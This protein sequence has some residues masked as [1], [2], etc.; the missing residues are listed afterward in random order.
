VRA[1]TADIDGELCGLDEDGLPSFAETQAATD[2]AS[3]THLVFYAFDLLHLDGSETARL[4]LNERKALLS[5]LISGIPG[6]QF[7]AHEI[8]DGELIRRHACKLGFEGV[9]SKK[10]DA[11]MRPAIAACGARRNASTGR[12]SLSLDGPIRKARGRT[13]WRC[14]SAIILMRASSFTPAGSA[15]ECPRRCLRICASLDPLRRPKS[16]LSAQPPPW[17]LAGRGWFLLSSVEGQVRV[18]GREDRSG[19]PDP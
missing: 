12:N 14:C 11:R 1:K 3:G 16:P 2:G 19:D 7:N 10:A 15:R 9:V 18:G 17:T 13:S 6:L 4:P 8:G 5:P